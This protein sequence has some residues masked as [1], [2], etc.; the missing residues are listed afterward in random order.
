MKF[1]LKIMSLVICLNIFNTPVNAASDT[2]TENPLVKIGLF[3][4]S[5]AVPTTN[6]D[7]YTS[8]GY[9]GG[10]HYLGY[11]DDDDEFVEI[12]DTDYEEITI[13]KDTTIYLGTDGLYYDSVLASPK[14]VIGAYH[15]ELS[16]SFDNASDAE[17]VA[18]TVADNAFVA[19]IDGEYKVRVA[20]YRT[21]EN[22]ENDLE[23]MIEKLGDED[24]QIVGGTE[25]TYTVTNTK[26]DTI[27]FEF[28][29]DSKFAVQ[30]KGEITWNKGYRYYGAFEYYRQYGG[31]I[32][33]INVVSMQDYV[34]GVVPYEM[35]G[36]WHIEALKAQAL[37]AR[38]Y[39]YNNLDKHSK[40][41]FDLCNDVDCQVYRG[42]S[43][44]TTNS[45]LAVDETIGQ[46]ISYEGEIATGFFHS[47]DG[48]AT[49]D[50]E[51]VWSTEVPYLRGVVDPYEQT[52]ESYYGIW[53][54]SITNEQIASILQ[55]KN[56]SINGVSDMYIS[57]YTSLG[58]V[59]TLTIEDL[60][61][62]EY[63]FSK[64]NARI[65]LNSTSNGITVNSTR[66]RINEK[67]PGTVFVSSDNTNVYIND[68]SFS[69]DF[70]FYIKGEDGRDYFDDIGGMSV[71]TA[72]GITE[73][74]LAESLETVESEPINTPDG[75]YV[76]D[77]RGWG[78]NV[79]MSQYGAKA[80][81]EMGFTA[82]EIITFYFTGTEVEH[83][84]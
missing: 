75:T 54:V 26:T 72:D 74:E 64:E 25:D 84:G 82:E 58:N 15:M 81:A 27:L 83:M 80:M 23:Y 52:Y 4:S 42:T 76:I 7:N 77:G 13:M 44:A 46:Y 43:Q 19:Y 24:I 32:S 70:G 8:E 1:L 71:I 33:V 59:Y 56:Y 3:Y 45:D 30:P 36:S 65:I 78:H 16:Q 61:G 67:M 51:N 12:Y 34:K 48:G 57:K 29:N 68:Q 41:G 73:I 47:S 40:Y 20:S 53:S 37:C 35:S 14:S 5:T 66:Y 63:N 17:Y 9:T 22:A 10:G 79:G 69:T 11:F 39:A 62:K 55:S 50:S 21:T 6:L 49:E 28:S 2:E 60:D 31:D 18:L 38:S